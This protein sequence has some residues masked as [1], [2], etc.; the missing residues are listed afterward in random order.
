MLISNNASKK[1]GTTNLLLHNPLVKNS[2]SCTF[3]RFSRAHC[4]FCLSAVTSNNKPP[5][6]SDRPRISVNLIDPVAATAAAGIELTAIMGIRQ[7]DTQVACAAHAPMNLGGDF[8]IS[9]KRESF[10]SCRTRWKRNDPT[11]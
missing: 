9:S 7:S 5:I 3:S 8:L 11:I 4:D 2:S 1:K 10:P 6:Y